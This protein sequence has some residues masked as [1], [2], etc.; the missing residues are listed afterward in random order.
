[1]P[2]VPSALPNV[3]ANARVGNS[4]AVLP[5]RPAAA[6]QPQPPPPVA[7]PQTPMAPPVSAAPPPAQAPQP[8]PAASPSMPPRQLPRETPAQAGR[9]LALITLVDRVADVVDLAPLKKSPTVDEALTQQID[10][11]VREQAKAM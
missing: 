5:N 3:P 11:T 4:T 2:R 9:R 1:A 6:A 7:P 10:R 8:R